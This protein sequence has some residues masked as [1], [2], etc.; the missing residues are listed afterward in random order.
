MP[1]FDT[2]AF[3]RSAAGQLLR[4]LA[5]ADAGGAPPADP[6][7]L[8]ARDTAALLELE[9]L[10]YVRLERGAGPLAW[11]LQRAVLTDAGRTRMQRTQP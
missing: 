5:E 6:N 1:E 11:R 10:G 8:D 7:T 3:E 9:R 2:G 4:R